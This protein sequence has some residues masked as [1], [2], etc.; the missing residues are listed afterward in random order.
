MEV[1]KSRKI[2][3]IS[4]KT[5]E[6]FKRKHGLEYFREWNK[7]QSSKDKRNVRLRERMK[8]D[9]NFKLIKNCRCRIRMVIKKNTKS[10]KTLSLLGCSTLF[11]KNYL[12]SK[13]LEGMT[14]GNRA[15]WHVDH[16][17]PC[18]S[19]DLSDPIQQKECFHYT[20]LQPLWAKDNIK[21]SDKL[22]W[23]N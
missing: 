4:R 14:W 9:I 2:Q 7:R 3:K 5:N 18:S 1:K 20:N 13:F 8:N 11:L 21:K 17:R 15:D 23:S 12:E 10:G 22:D 6:N 19:F 16:I